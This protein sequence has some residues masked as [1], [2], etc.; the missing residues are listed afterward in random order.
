MSFRSPQ[1]SRGGS[2]KGPLCAHREGHSR[3]DW[4]VR[5]YFASTSSSKARP[6][7]NASSSAV[8]HQKAASVMPES[9]ERIFIAVG[10]VVELV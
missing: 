9:A 3:A 5:T 10:S 8:T 6:R 4:V 7:A 2:Q 1:V